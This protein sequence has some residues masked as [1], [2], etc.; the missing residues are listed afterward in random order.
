MFGRLAH[1]YWIKGGFYL[2]LG[3]ST[4]IDDLAASRSLTVLGNFGQRRTAGKE[5]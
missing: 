2:G 4:S 1:R 3:I 5:Q